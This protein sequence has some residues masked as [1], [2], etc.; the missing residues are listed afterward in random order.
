MEGGSSLY[1]PFRI[2][3]KVAYRV[4]R[5]GRQLRY[6][7]DRKF[8]GPYVIT[9]V[10]S[11]NVS[12]EITQC[13]K[14]GGVIKA[15]HKQLKS[16]QDPPRYLQKYY[17]SVVPCPDNSI[18]SDSDFPILGAFCGTT[19]SGDEGDLARSSLS[20]VVPVVEPCRRVY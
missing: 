1:S 13:D 16:W 2:G 5:V 14:T 15:N 9:K 19:S 18:T 10:Q 8:D 12:Y 6:K 11:N 7:L 20:S 3:Q 4:N 17:G